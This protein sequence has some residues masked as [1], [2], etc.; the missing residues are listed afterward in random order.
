LCGFA[1]NVPVC[2]TPDD[3]FRNEW[4]RLGNDSIQQC[5]K[6][7]TFRVYGGLM[8]KLLVLALLFFSASQTISH[9]P[10]KAGSAFLFARVQFNMDRRWIFDYREAPWHHDYPF[11]EDLFLTMVNEVTGI[12]TTRDS[13]KVVQLDGR[14]LFDYPWVYISEPGYLSLTAGE[15]T[16]LRE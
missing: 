8:K 1:C 6:A 14:D 7:Y 3:T 11:S 16:N 9:L 4:Q 5:H 2:D 10:E 12:H 15:I 13:Y